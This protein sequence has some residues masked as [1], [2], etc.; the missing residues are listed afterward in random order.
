[1]VR[2]NFNVNDTSYETS[3]NFALKLK[4]LKKSWMRLMEWESWCCYQN[5][6]QSFVSVE[7]HV[8]D[9]TLKSDLMTLSQ[10]VLMSQT[11]HNGREFCSKSSQDSDEMS[12]RVFPSN[13]LIHSFIRLSN[14]T[15]SQLYVRFKFIY[16]SLMLVRHIHDDEHQMKIRIW[17]LAEQ[18]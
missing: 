18:I 5:F 2:D 8:L 14:Q 6:A 16:K 13:W 3:G 10:N 15:Q 12:W 17:R 11:V 1:M 9:V 4:S 7:L